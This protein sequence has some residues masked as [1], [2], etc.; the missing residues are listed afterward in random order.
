MSEHI[1]ERKYHTCA[2]CNVY[3]GVGNMPAYP[4]C[5]G[6]E[7]NDSQIYCLTVISKMGAVRLPST[8]H[9]AGWMDAVNMIPPPFMQSL[10]QGYAMGNI[11]VKEMSQHI[12]EQRIMDAWYSYDGPMSFEQFYATYIPA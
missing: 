8:P 7:R 10:I 1:M 2:V 12:Y 11:E 5:G 9:K 3:M 4:V 6:C